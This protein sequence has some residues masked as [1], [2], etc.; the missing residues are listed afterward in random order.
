MSPAVTKLLLPHVPAQLCAAA[1]W[2]VNAAQYCNLQL[3]G[4]VAVA[5]YKLCKP[6]RVLTH[7]RMMGH[8]SVSLSSHSRTTPMVRTVQG[9]S[10]NDGRLSARMTL[11]PN[12]QGV[13]RYCGSAWCCGHTGACTCVCLRVQVYTCN[14]LLCEEV[15][16]GRVCVDY[17]CVLNKSTEP[18]KIADA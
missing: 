14:C 8:R 3:A 7:M 12:M 6:W 11:S 15:L 16:A 17:V 5:A 10:R 2:G 18:G 9:R 1:R 4:S 13:F